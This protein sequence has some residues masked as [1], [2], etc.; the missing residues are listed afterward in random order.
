MT[1]MLAVTE[2][3]LWMAYFMTGERS[4]RVWGLARKVHMKRR[5]KLIDFADELN[6]QEQYD[7]PDNDFLNWVQ[8][9]AFKTYIC[10]V[11][12]IAMIIICGYFDDPA[13]Y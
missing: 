12:I 4:K 7:G 11:V 1:M 9:Q 6:L 13:L 5:D 8:L 3:L 10:I 2:I